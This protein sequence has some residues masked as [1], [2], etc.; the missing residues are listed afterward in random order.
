MRRQKRTPISRSSFLS[1]DIVRRAQVGKLAKQIEVG[2]NVILR[3]LPVCED[4]HEDVTGIVGKCPAIARE[5]CLAGG[6]IGQYL[7]QQRARHLHCLLW[8]ISTRVLKRV[9]KDR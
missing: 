2:P 8:R 1:S 6:V 3:H 4:G 9:S 5:G 7:R